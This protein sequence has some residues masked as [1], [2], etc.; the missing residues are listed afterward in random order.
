MITHEMILR[1]V[2]PRYYKL[3][4]LNAYDLRFHDAYSAYALERVEEDVVSLEDGDDL[5]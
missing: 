3:D 1:G 4:Q 2:V 5:E